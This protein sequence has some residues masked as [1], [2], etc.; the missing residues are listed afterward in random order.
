MTQLMDYN[1]VV[2]GSNGY[3]NNHIIQL[4][5]K[6][7]AQVIGID[8]VKKPIFKNTKYKYFRCDITK[9][10]EVKSFF[11][12]IKNIKIDVLINAAAINPKISK[13]KSFKKFTDY[14]I[15]NWKK[16]IDVNL[17]GSIILSKHICKIFEKNNFN[18]NIINISSI[19]GIKAQDQKIYSSKQFKNKMFKP[20]EYAVSKSGLESFTRNLASYYQNTNIRDNTLS[21]GG[22]LQ[23]KQNQAFKNNYSRKTI[24]GRLANLEDYNESLI[25][26]CKKN[27]NYLTGANLVVDGGSTVI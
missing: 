24:V 7:G 14:P 4:L 18:G 6:E 17:L 19:Y 10:N 20:L 22:V 15:S 11:K 23:S 16:S 3:L 12:K 25:F 5:I 13:E 27:N 2:S 1:I 26:L 9:E 8:I 21:P